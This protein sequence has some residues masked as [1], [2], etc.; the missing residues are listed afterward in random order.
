MNKVSESIW[1]S[2]DYAI[3]MSEVS[4]I[5]KTFY[6]CDLADGSKKGDYSGV[7]VIMKHSKIDEYGNYHPA[8]R[9]PLKDGE[10]FMS[11]WCFY[12]HELEGGKE[13]FFQPIAPSQ[14]EEK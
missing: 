13:A 14:Q 2:K 4:Y 6:S 10:Q 8:I 3:P 9:I 11:D 12:R 7:L 1:S 5:E